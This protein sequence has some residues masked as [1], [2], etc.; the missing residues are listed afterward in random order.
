MVHRSLS[1]H[2]QDTHLIKK[3]NTHAQSNAFK[4]SRVAWEYNRCV[5]CIMH[6]D[7][8]IS[9]TRVLQQDTCVTKQPQTR[10]PPNQTRLIPMQTHE[11]SS[12]WGVSWGWRLYRD[13]NVYY[14]ALSSRLRWYITFLVP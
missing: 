4:H 5:I 13:P 11:V 6:Y 10:H 12:I 7:C 3:V 8:D 14:E 1:N 9:R 2:K